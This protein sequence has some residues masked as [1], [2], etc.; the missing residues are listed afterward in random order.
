MII[1]KFLTAG[2]VQVDPGKNSEQVFIKI[3]HED[4]S[5]NIVSKPIDGKQV[6]YY[7]T[8]IMRNH[9]F[10]SFYESNEVFGIPAHERAEMNKKVRDTPA[11]DTSTSKMN[12]KNGKQKD[13]NQINLDKDDES[14]IDSFLS[15]MKW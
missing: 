1:I 7:K 2:V 3:L 13:N 6:H 5:V 4:G 10:V 12:I 11:E 15:T 14:E 8:T 9:G